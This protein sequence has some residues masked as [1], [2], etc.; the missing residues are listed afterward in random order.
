MKEKTSIEKSHSRLS[1]FK[2]SLILI[3]GSLAF[4]ALWVGLII[5]KENNYLGLTIFAIGAIIAIISLLLIKK[6]VR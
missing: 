6:F 1:N 3:I 5:L 2:L 4:F